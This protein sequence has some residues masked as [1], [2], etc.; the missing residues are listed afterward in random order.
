MVEKIAK[1]GMLSEAEVA[2]NA[3]R[4]AHESAARNNDTHGNDDRSAHVGYYLID[5]GLA[6]LE[7]LAGVRLSVTEALRKA[8]GRFPLFLYLGT[9]TLI[10]AIFTGGL[11]AKANDAGLQPWLFAGNGSPLL[12]VCES[13]GNR[14]GELACDASGNAAFTAANGLLQRYSA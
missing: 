6:Q 12:T 8:S 5:K 4:L 13:A 10:T 3:V 7:R 14:R 1:T 2:A 11:L 9:I